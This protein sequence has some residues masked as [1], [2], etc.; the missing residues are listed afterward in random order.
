MPEER[1]TLEKAPPASAILR[2]QNNHLESLYSEGRLSGS[3]YGKQGGVVLLREWRRI[4]YRHKWMIL[5]IILAALPFIVIQ[6]YRAKS[7]YQATATIEVRREDSSLAKAGDVYY[8]GAYD[9]TKAEAFIIK[10][11]PVIKKT[12]SSLKLDRN[13]RL[14]DVTTK[15]S[16]W[17]AILALK[18]GIGGER[19]SG[20]E[21]GNEA[22]GKEA[23]AVIDSEEGAGASG[24][25]GRSPDSQAERARLE[26]YIEAL[27]SNL[28]VE[29]VRDTRLMKLSFTH[30]DPE[31]AAA[32]ANGVAD[33]FIKHNF[34]TKTERFTDASNWLEESTRK[35]KAQVEQAEAALANYSRQKDIFSLEGKEN[36][37]AEKLVRLHDQVM[38][39]ETDRLLKQSLH[40]EVIR[41]RVAQ[42]P[43][44]FADP[45]T[46][47]LRKTLNELAVQ[48]SQVSVKFGA[49]H[50]KL[51]EIRQQMNT[52]Q[53]QIDANRAMLEERLKADYER[54]VREEDSLRA[55]LNQ[56][57]TEAVQQN[58]AA[59]QYSVLQQDLVTAKSLYTD[60][61]N[62]TSQANIQRAEQYN[63]V[64]LIEAAE[65]PGTPIGPNRAQA[66][67]IGFLIS[68]AFGVGL[69]YLLE[70]L[71]TTVR[72]V[73]DVSRSTQLPILAVIPSLEDKSLSAKRRAVGELRDGS[74]AIA[75]VEGNSE[76][77]ILSDSINDFSAATE[78]YRMLRT[79]V[80]LSTAE[81]PPKTI[82]VTSGQP[83]DG[84]TTTVYNTA[85]VFTQLKA[86]VLVIDCDMRKPRLHSMAHIKREQGLS[87]FLS[88]GG[89]LA[90]LIKPTTTPYLSILPCG[91]VPPNPSELISSDKMKEL[92]SLLSEHYDYIFIDSPPLVTVTD[93]LILSTFVDGVIL[94]IKSG[95]SKS[96]IARRA[97]QDLA[98][99]GAKVLGVVLNDLN[100]RHEGYDYYNYSRY[101][102]D[103]VDYA[104]GNGA[105]G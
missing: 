64:R 20:K 90:E 12:I 105:G 47:E 1:V 33:S 31:L 57:K 66:I 69:A 52:I 86:R 29:G 21:S 50:P 71:N 51:V 91:H 3:I 67:L 38:R 45:K 89:D 8:Y 15:R 14:L 17:G 102:S 81:R 18:G 62:K 88:S 40:E 24:S 35:L 70:R 73:D 46:A 96:E 25:N 37:T 19:E 22:L 2:P 16:V 23:A 4:I 59:I 84:K 11:Q 7:L 43:E 103:Y 54:A 36:L 56:A 61:L 55:A 80:L 58:Q 41:G 98:G 34:Q 85:V 32:V 79:A 78:S 44:A 75:Q 26:P 10:S 65:P 101:Y 30:T 48:A 39:A 27:A 99:V 42:L 104:K 72:N 60:F 9:N 94:V 83:G 28:K 6:T 63:N 68:L 95:K 82:L 77:E 93:P 76:K 97:C 87:T 74:D 100:V 13:S 53:E 92:L 49:K 5:S